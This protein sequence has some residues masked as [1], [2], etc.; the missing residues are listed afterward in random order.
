MN[1]IS[2]NTSQNSIS[3]KWIENL[4]IEEINMDETGII[5][6]DS[7]LDPSLYLEEASVELMNEL[8]ERFEIFVEKFNEY[9]GIESNATIKIFKISNTIN[10]FML[11]R[12]SL[13]LIFS[14]RSSDVIQ[15]NFMASGKDLY[16][17]RSSKREST[18]QDN[19]H[20][21][22]AHIGPFN[23]ISWLFDGE[24][25]EIDPL[26]KH[27]LSEFIKNSAR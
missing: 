17:A 9:R 25:I 16:T 6:L 4:A 14:R 3:T 19:V 12:N 20:E 18:F 24:K 15:V 11:F 1:I 8:R 5:D 22:K 27:Y 21:I 23:N 13:R 7:H 2:D 10:D 26:V